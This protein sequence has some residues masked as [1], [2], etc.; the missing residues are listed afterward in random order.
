[1]HIQSFSLARVVK[2]KIKMIFKVAKRINLK[3]EI[4]INCFPAEMTVAVHR[5]K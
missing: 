4:W 1:M 5:I 2:T 3:G